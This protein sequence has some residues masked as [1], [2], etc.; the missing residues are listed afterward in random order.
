MTE[1]LGGKNL[2]TFLVCNI[3]GAGIFIIFP[4]LLK[5]TKS[6][7]K[8]MF[9]LLLSGLIVMAFGLCYAELGATYPEEGG[10]AVY[11][12]KAYNTTMSIVFSIFSV[13]IILPLGVALMLKHMMGTTGID[14]KY[15]IYI[16]LVIVTALIAINYVSSDMVIKIQY[17]LTFCKTL[18]L[19]VFVLFAILTSFNLIKTNNTEDCALKEGSIED[20]S[21]LSV[22]SGSTMVLWAFDGWNAGNFIG[23]RIRNPAFTFPVA[24][25]SAVGLVLVIYILFGI[26]F[27]SVLSFNQIINTLD[28]NDRTLVNDFFDSLEINDN[29]NSIVSTCINIIPPFGTMNGSFLIATSIIDSFTVDKENSNYL[30]LSGLVVFGLIVTLGVYIKETWRI[31]DSLSFFIYLWYGLS[32]IGILLLRNKDKEVKRDL[33][34]PKLLIYFCAIMSPIIMFLSLKRLL[35]K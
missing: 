5:E 33:K 17:V 34:M 11:L 16:T 22:L 12:Q 4:V 27:M 31:V 32:I 26:S 28:I 19:F 24:I 18:A 10:D 9:S 6:V 30:K 3:I 1:K 29:V 35:I 15:H 25:L 20:K 13:Y 14:P 8:S 21:I 2:F 23:N 7:Q